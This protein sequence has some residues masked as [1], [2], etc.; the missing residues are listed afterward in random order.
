MPFLIAKHYL[1]AKE[2]RLF[3]KGVTESH[4]ATCKIRHH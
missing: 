4:G 3:I 1:E 2:R